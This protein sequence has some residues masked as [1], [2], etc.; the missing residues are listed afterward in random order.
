MN[1]ILF[2]GD[3]DICKALKHELK[4]YYFETVDYYGTTTNPP[5]VDDECIKKYF[6]K[7][8][9]ATVLVTE[10]QEDAIQA[11]RQ[12]YKGKVIGLLFDKTYNKIPGTDETIVVSQGDDI[13]KPGFASELI[14]I[15]NKYK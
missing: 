15:I 8:N 5:W 9:I 13:I 11:T 12:F 14:E 1:K 7:N 10:G 6:D 3:E 4:L 2:F